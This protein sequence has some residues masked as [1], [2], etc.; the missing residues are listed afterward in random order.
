[1][2]IDGGSDHRRS[3]GGRPVVGD[4]ELGRWVGPE[5]RMTLE[6]EEAERRPKTKVK[7]TDGPRGTQWVR[8][9]NRRP[10]KNRKKIACRPTANSPICSLLLD[11]RH[12]HKF[13]NQQRSLLRLPGW[14]GSTYVRQRVESLQ[15]CFGSG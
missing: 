3:F 7:R 6:R 15:L 2:V 4:G 1:V 9:R 11:G 10:L 5:G 12:V 13:G 14:F 8:S